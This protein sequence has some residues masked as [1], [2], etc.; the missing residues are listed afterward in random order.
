[1]MLPWKGD[2]CL[3]LLCELMPTVA[4]EDFIVST[5]ELEMAMRFGPA[6]QYTVVKAIACFAK[7]IESLPEEERDSLLNNMATNRRNESEESR[8]S[9]F[10]KK[11]GRSPLSF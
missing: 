2:Q 1:M 4:D 11:A 3:A 8:N 10:T 6:T 5:T 7:R 9:L